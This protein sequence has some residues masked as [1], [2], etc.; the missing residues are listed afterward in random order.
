MCKNLTV[1]G[2][3]GISQLSYSII[4]FVNSD[5]TK[6]CRAKKTLAYHSRSTIRKSVGHVVSVMN[7]AKMLHRALYAT[8]ETP[9]RSKY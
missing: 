8:Y 6:I 2:D 9:S 4:N 7:D 3:F 5:I 1:N